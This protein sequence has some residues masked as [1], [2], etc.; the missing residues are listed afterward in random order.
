MTAGDKNA[1]HR[2]ITVTR[3]YCAA[4][5]RPTGATAEAFLQEMLPRL[6]ELYATALALP[7]VEPADDDR[8]W[9]GMT[10]EEWK[11]VFD[12]LR[13]RIVD[14]Q[15]YWTTDGFPLRT[16][17][18]SPPLLCGDLANDLADIYRDLKDSLDQWETGEDSHRVSALW[19][20][21]F[22][23]HAHYGQHI[24]DAVRVIHRVVEGRDD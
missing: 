15:L 4:V 20:W 6:V 21:R 18:T 17:D 3:N 19:E 14:Y 8:E 11:V 24:V 5:E 22:G 7:D 16:D 2:F 13:E 10:H 1:I 9:P 12:D 23:F